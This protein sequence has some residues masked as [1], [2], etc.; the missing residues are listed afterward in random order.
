MAFGGESAESYYDEGLTAAMKGAWK[1]AITSFETAIAKDSNMATAHHQLGKVYLRTGETKK[2][3]DVLGQVTQR[4]P[5]LFPAG[6]DFGFALLDAQKTANARMVFGELLDRKPDNARVQLGLAQCAFEEGDWHAAFSLAEAAAAHPG[7]GFNTYLLLGRAA[8]LA[9]REDTA[10]EALAKAEALIDKYIE[11]A[12]ENPEGYYLRGEVLFARDKF[13]DALDS[14][15]A[16]ED[17][18][19]EDAAFVSFGIRFGKVTI[20]T[21]RALCLQRLGRD[22]DAC[23]VGEQLL[24]LDPENTLGKML[25]KIE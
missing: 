20:L 25:A 4:W 14:F 1:E 2:A 18:C 6:I 7:A 16:A 13:S 8:K 17:R 19:A 12:P 10:K 23:I 22:S 11:T 3:L 24:R 5:G 9:G 15:R 21:K